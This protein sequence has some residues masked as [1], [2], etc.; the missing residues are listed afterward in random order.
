MAEISLLRTVKV[1]VTTGHVLTGFTMK[2]VQF[3]VDKQ[4]IVI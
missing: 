4:S 2:F 3:Q 1:L